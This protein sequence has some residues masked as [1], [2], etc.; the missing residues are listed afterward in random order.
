[1]FDISL[2][3]EPYILL[4]A[5]IFLRMIA[6]VFSSALFGLQNISAA[7]K[8][9]L[10][11]SLTSMTFALVRSQSIYTT[12]VMAGFSQG[13]VFLAVKE[14]ITGLVIGFLTR[15]FF[16]AVSMTGDL[17]SVYMGLS[18]AQLFNPMT[19]STGNSMEQ[20]HTLMGVLVLLAINGHHSFLS[21]ILQS[22]EL[23]PV[24]SA[25]LKVGSLAEVAYWGQDVLIMAIKM[26]APILVAILTA[27]VAMAILARVVP[28][29]NVLI[30]GA[31]ITFGLGIFIL[32]ICMPLWVL[33][34]NGI[35]QLTSEKLMTVIK[36]L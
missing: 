9:L 22:F 4:F 13:I 23:I 30:T 20:F 7:I 21:G 5:L 14:L 6:F 32:V 8:I 3:S 16:F 34:M 28:Q 33:E 24:S 27:N 11:L 2:L 29:I 35:L 17:V 10:A 26:S 15:L 36:S 31:P 18:N 12:E 25:S 1:M 19:N